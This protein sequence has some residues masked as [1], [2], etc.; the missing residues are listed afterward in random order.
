MNELRDLIGDQAVKTLINHLGGIS[1]WVPA[2]FD[3]SKPQ[4]NML[5]QLIGVD[6]T[7]QLISVYGGDQLHVP[8]GIR[9][10]NAARNADI[11]AAR[12]NGM[13]I[14]AIARKHQ[15]TSRWVYA[16]ISASTGHPYQLPLL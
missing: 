16:I 10:A 8:R 6:N 7:Q 12:D 13:T 15:L 11:I 14:S 9:D 4:C 2:I 5:T 1:V 3:P